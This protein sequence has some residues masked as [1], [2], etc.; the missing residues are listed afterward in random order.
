MKH[1]VGKMIIVQGLTRI[2]FIVS[3]FV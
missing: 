1:A 3:E 2:F